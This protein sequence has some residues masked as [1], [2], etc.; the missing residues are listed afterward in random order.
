MSM[1]VFD[2][3]DLAAAKMQETALEEAEE[4]INLA[5]LAG[6]DVGDAN[7]R[8]LAILAKLR[9]FRQAFFPGR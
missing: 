7:E 6:M 8:R 2:D 9:G 5:K 1:N 4:V 3:E